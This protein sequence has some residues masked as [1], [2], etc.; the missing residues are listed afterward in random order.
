MWR[1]EAFGY[2]LSCVLDEREAAKRSLAKIEELLASFVSDSDD[3]GG[4]GAGD[5]DDEEDGEEDEV[6][7]ELDN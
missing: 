3:V 7:D 6:E 4:S 5:D 1:I 2:E